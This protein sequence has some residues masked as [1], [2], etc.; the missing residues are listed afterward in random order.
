MRTPA[1]LRPKVMTAVMTLATMAGPLGFLAAGYALRHVALGSFF[2]G[3]PAL[4]T[5][6]SL[7]FAG[8]A[9]QRHQRE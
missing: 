1:E 4:L 6:G 3:L 5:L 8:V 2:I 7:A 9:A